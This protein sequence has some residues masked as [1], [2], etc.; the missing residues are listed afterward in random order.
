MRL[1]T[2]SGP[3]GSFGYVYDAA[4]NLTGEHYPDGFAAAWSYDALH[5]ELSAAYQR[6]SD[7]SPLTA[8]TLGYD[9]LSRRTGVTFADGSTQAYAYDAANRVH[10]IVHGFP[11]TP[12]GRTWS[13]STATTRPVAT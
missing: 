6:A 10:T 9:P 4:S 13:T 8:A 12:R 5:R 7:P 11:P 1:A 3:L 2:A